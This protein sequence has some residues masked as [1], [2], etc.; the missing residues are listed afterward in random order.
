MNLPLK[1]IFDEKRRLM[2][3]VLAG[4]ALNIVLYVAVVYPMSVRA[5][6]AESRAARAEAALHAAE[7]DERSARGI[8]E[9]RDRTDVA[10]KSFYKDVLPASMAEAQESTYLRLAQ[11]ADQHN[12][13]RSRTNADQA[14]DRESSLVRLQ[15]TTSLQGEYE[16]LRRFIYQVESGTDFIVID[17]IALRQGGEPGA[18]LTLDLHLST[19]FRARP[20]GA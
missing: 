17:S 3:P 18:P 11:L 4:L 14:T 2:I 19:Y 1:R 5:R 6:T 15:I 20:G 12:V 10:L 13:R 8:A 16:D 7:R 9:G